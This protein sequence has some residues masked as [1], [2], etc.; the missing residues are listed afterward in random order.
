MEQNARKRFTLFYINRQGN[1]SSI[2]QQAS[3]T[4]FYLTFYGT[5]V[6][7][8]IVFS[9]ESDKVHAQCISHNKNYN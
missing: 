9:R 4:G 5:S 7:H 3:L 2:I 1:V 6:S 8:G